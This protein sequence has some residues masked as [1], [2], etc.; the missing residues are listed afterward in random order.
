MTRLYMKSD[1]FSAEVETIPEAALRQATVK[2]EQSVLLVI[3]MQNYFWGI[4]EPI[5]PNL[6][7]TIEACRK[8]NV[9]VMYTQHG[10]D[11]PDVESGML[12]EWWGDPIIVGTENWKFI[13]E[14]APFEDETVIRKMRYNAFYGT[15]LETRFR[16]IGVKNVIISGV[17]TNLCCETTAREAFVRDF[18]V[19]FLTDGTATVSDVYQQATLRNL[20]YGFAYLKRCEEVVE[21]LT[22]G[23]D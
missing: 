8:A 15:D 21:E 22:Q 17:M 3:D 5:I 11:E 2:K 7:K 6:M 20:A 10:Y 4:A 14:T 23:Q 13:P 9:P 1:V 19:F 16:K 18:R 12:G